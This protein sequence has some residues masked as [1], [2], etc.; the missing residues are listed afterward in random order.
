MDRSD[1]VTTRSRTRSIE[2][3]RQHLTGHRVPAPV[4]RNPDNVV[5]RLI[6]ERGS[7]LRFAWSMPGACMR[8]SHGS[9]R[10]GDIRFEW[11]P[12]HRDEPPESDTREA[13]GWSS[14]VRCNRK[15]VRRI[16]RSEAPGEGSLHAPPVDHGTTPNRECH[17][18]DLRVQ[19]LNR[20]ANC[21]R[22]VRTYSAI[23]FLLSP[24]LARGD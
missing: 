3:T 4:F 20:I 11:H 23:T 13:L 12:V 9:T 19:E 2:S 8:F 1:R 15:P 18:S 14:A 22:W 6:F 10:R 5:R 24:V 7:R 17:G 16:N 21:V